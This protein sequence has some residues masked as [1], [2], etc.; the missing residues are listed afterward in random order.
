MSR[1]RYIVEV[2]DAIPVAA[3]FLYCRMVALDGRISGNGKQHCYHT[4]FND[5]VA[6]SCIKRGLS[7]RFVVSRK[8]TA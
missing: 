5:G 2:H 3:A 8:E 4:V 1:E 6:V 7:E